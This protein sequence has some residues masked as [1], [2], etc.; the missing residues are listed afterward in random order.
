VAQNTIRKR[1]STTHSH[2]LGKTNIPSQQYYQFKVMAKQGH[3]KKI[4]AIDANTRVAQNIYLLNQYSKQYY[5]SKID[6]RLSI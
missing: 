3:Q 4:T 6:N 1:L 5:Q 2:N